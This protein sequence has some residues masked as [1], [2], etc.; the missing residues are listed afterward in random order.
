MYLLQYTIYISLS[1][2]APHNAVS[3]YTLDV[4]DLIFVRP[5]DRRRGLGGIMMTHFLSSCTSVEDLGFS[6]PLSA[7]VENCKSRA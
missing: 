2:G 1:L 3:C 4:L 7:G 5:C 6:S